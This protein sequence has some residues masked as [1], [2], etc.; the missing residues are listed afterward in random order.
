MGL[1]VAAYR[2]IT[3]IDCLF[4]ADG[5]PFDPATGDY[6]DDKYFQ[7]YVNPDFPDRADTLENKAIYSYT[8]RYHFRAG[9]YSYYNRWRDHLAMI[10]GYALGSY[11]QY[12]IKYSS[13]AVS[14]WECES[15]PFLELIMFSDCEGC[16]GPA[17]SAK[18][19]KDF[20][21]Y[22]DKADAVED[23]RWKEQ[24]ANFRKSFEMASDQGAVYFG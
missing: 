2:K 24:Y 3:K 19:A 22:Q 9:A 11:E 23:D 13:Y 4:D 20:A 10:A 14:A 6:I 12:G 1:D 5:E 16:I 18:L 15:G 7:A 8:D 17:T 21:D